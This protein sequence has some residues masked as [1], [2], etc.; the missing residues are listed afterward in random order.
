[1]RGDCRVRSEP[2]GGSRGRPRDVEFDFL[3]PIAARDLMHL[4]RRRAL[5]ERLP[6]ETGQP[7][8]GFDR[9]DAARLAGEFGRYDRKC[10]MIR[11]DIDK[12]VARQDEMAQHLRQIVKLGW[13][14][15]EARIVQIEEHRR[16]ADS[17]RD[18]AFICQTAAQRDDRAQQQFGADRIASL[19]RAVTREPSIGPRQ[20]ARENRVGQPIKRRALVEPRTG[21]PVNALM[22]QARAKNFTDRGPQLRVNFRIKM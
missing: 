13:N 6:Q 14:L 15:K 22:H 19:R 2:S 17:Q 10:S 18:R 4:E 9:D 21:T 16:H 11:A 3:T 12:S 8:L 7:R 20:L 5:R 1:M